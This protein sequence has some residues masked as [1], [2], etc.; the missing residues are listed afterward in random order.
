MG[1]IDLEFIQKWITYESHVDTF[2]S[3]PVLLEGQKAAEFIAI[4][5]QF[6]D[7]PAAPGP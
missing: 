2:L 5:S 1:Q 6:L 3:E 7:S 4:I